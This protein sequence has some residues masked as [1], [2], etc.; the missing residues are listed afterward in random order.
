MSFQIEFFGALSLILFILVAMAVLFT[1]QQK[2]SHS[3]PKSLEIW[4]GPSG[5]VEGRC[6][7]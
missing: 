7:P 6:R 2:Q 5:G 1:S 3:L 4:L